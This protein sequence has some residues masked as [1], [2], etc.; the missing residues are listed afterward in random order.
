MDKSKLSLEL[1]KKVYL[2]RK[3]E[4]T[5]IKYYMDDDMKTPVH[6]SVG[7]EAIAA[8]VCHA[9]GKD[10]QIYGTYRNHGIYLARTG[11]TDNFFGELYGKKTG[12]AKGKA[13]SMHMFCPECNFL[14][15][16]AIVA[17]CI[18]LGLGGAFAKKYKK[19]KGLSFVFF[20]DGALEEGAFWESLNFACLHKLPII[21]VC[22]DNG[23][24]IHSHI[25]DRQ[26]FKSITDIV[27]KFGCNVFKEKSTD[28]EVIHN[29]TLEAIKKQKENGKPCFMHLKYYRYLEHVGINQDF[30][31]G[32]RSE[33]E[34]KKWL[35]VDPVNLQR[36]KLLKIGF[37]EK[38]I[39]KVETEIDKQ[40]DKSVEL[41]EKAPFPDCEEVLTDV[42]S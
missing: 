2:I 36:K 41:A 24:A 28:P 9:T 15:T 7:E 40:I 19:E 37:S 42:Y 18:P 14:G 21:F 23:L 33:D 10:D 6:L 16:S 1:Y 5:I 29:L 39:K 35:K 34:F 17:T 11:E 4:E 32:Y 3:S 26:S 8:G 20:G 38:E 25:K 12:M 31:F 27:S 22:E 13:G 30:K